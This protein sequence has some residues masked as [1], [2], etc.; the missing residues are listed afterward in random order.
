MAPPTPTRFTRSQQA[1]M[2]E[3][4]PVISASTAV[5]DETSVDG[6]VFF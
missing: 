3:A 4:G 2:A 6:G 5:G 1:K